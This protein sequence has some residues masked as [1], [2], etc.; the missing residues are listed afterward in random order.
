MKQRLEKTLSTELK[1][2]NELILNCDW[3]NKDFY[4]DYIAQTFYYVRHSTRLLALA[5]SRLNYEQEQKIHLRFI[6]HLKEESNHEK[7]A[8][9]DLSHLDFKIENF[10]EINATRLFYEPQYYKIEHE[11]PLALMG[12]VL[13]LEAL[14]QKVCPSLSKKI[15]GYHGNKTATFIHVHGEE[16]PGHVEKALRMILDLNQQD[17][18]AIENNLIQSS[19]VYSQL[20]TELNLKWNKSIYKKSA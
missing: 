10:P 4:A 5:A 12:Y 9:S 20:L 13:F 14:A 8:L 11:R 2:S 3:K 1:N 18:L 16:D 7:L 19:Y 15:T 17:L 6:S